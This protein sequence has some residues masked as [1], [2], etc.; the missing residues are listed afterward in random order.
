LPRRHTIGAVHDT[1]TKKEKTVEQ[2][3][4]QDAGNGG[5]TTV[6]EITRGVDSAAVSLDDFDRRLRP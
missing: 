1:A 5:S 2:D 6:E 4:T 3:A